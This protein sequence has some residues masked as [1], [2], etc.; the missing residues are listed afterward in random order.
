MR[1][2]VRILVTHCTRRATLINPVCVYARDCV[3]FYWS[4]SRSLNKKVSGTCWMFEDDGWLSLSVRNVCL[5]LF[6]CWWNLRK[7]LCEWVWLSFWKHFWTCERLRDLLRKRDDQKVAY[8]ADANGT[9]AWYIYFSNHCMIGW[10]IAIVIRHNLFEEGMMIWLIIRGI[11]K[12]NERDISEFTWN[13]NARS[14]E[15]ERVINKEDVWCMFE[16]V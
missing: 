9:N 12:T 4:S 8:A 11:V 13:T 3:T 10:E 1:K 15:R 2:C 7:L 16:E 6:V 14:C 5:C